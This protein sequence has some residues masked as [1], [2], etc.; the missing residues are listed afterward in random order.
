MFENHPVPTFTSKCSI[1]I[2]VGGFYSIGVSVGG[3]YSTG[4]SVGQWQGVGREGFPEQRGKQHPREAGGWESTAGGLAGCSRG[5][6]G[7][8]QISAASETT[9]QFS[10]RHCVPCLW[11]LVPAGVYPYSKDLHWPPIPV[12]I[13]PPCKSLS[14]FLTLLPEPITFLLDSSS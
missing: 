13:L 6:E 3:F 12:Q 5:H 1:G 10:N 9:L 2:S 8:F 11:I 7:N 4:V 14:V